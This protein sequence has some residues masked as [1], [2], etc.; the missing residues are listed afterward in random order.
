MKNS[1]HPVNATF[2]NGSLAIYVS[3]EKLGPIGSGDLNIMR[4][5]YR[6]CVAT[7]KA[8]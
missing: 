8:K 5:T 4:F 7:T 3:S 1:H 2:N 6:L